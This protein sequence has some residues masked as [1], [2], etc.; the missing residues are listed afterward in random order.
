MKLPVRQPDLIKYF[1][2]A[3]NVEFGSVINLSVGGTNSTAEFEVFAGCLL[4]IRTANSGVGDCRWCHLKEV[5]S[6]EPV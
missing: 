2:S 1:L 4:L 6:S 3:C 5:G